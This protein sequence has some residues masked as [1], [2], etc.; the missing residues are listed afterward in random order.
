V[1][2]AINKPMEVLGK[3]A[4]RRLFAARARKGAP[5][6]VEIH[7]TEADLALAMSTVAQAAWNSAFEAMQKARAKTDREIEEE[8]GS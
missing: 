7:I 3:Y 8:G 5:A 2:S 6:Q 1:S 4:A